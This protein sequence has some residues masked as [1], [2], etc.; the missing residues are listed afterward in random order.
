MFYH[1]KCQE[2][3]YGNQ[4]QGVK[5][6]YRNNT[7]FEIDIQ[8]QRKYF[9]TSK[10]QLKHFFFFIVTYFIGLLDYIYFYRFFNWTAPGK[11]DSN[12]KVTITSSI[13]SQFL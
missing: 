13:P 9:K 10:G 4:L 11:G 7:L 6:I 3:L 12:V 1:S 5:L 2:K 8:W